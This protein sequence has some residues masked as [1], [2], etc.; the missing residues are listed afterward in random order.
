MQPAARTATVFALIVGCVVSCS[1]A[2]PTAET[3]NELL[4]QATATLTEMTREE[5]GTESLARKG[6]GYALFPEVAK[7][8]L[9]LV[10][11]MAGVSC[12]SRDSLSAMPT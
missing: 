7:G 1:T 8:G 11:H 12:T 3:R 9:V 10:A 4:E 2:P 5:P 6:Y